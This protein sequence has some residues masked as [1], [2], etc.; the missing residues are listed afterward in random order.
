MAVRN[1]GFP[2]RSFTRP[3]DNLAAVLA[4]YYFALKHEYEFVF[5]LVPVSVRRCRTRHERAEIDAEL[6][7]TGRPAE[8]LARAPLDGLSNGGG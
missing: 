3:E 1:A 4:E 6:R 8:A 5:V 2:S 7:E